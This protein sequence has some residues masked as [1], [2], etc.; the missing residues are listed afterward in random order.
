MGVG[1]VRVTVEDEGRRRGGSLSLRGRVPPKTGKTTFPSGGV[2]RPQ[3][4]L[5]VSDGTVTT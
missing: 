4:S 2:G 1:R 5:P 3:S